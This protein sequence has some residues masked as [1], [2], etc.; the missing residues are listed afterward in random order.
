MKDYLKPEV[1]E[2]CF[3]TENVATM[4]SISNAGEGGGNAP[5]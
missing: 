1:E 2:I 3:N 4:G 5:G